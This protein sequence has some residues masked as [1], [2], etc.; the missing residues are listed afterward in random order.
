MKP[1]E[2]F[3]FS[4][5]VNAW[6]PVQEEHDRLLDRISLATYNVWFA[7]YLWRERFAGLLDT[8]RDWDPDLIALQEVTPRHLQHLLSLRWVRDHYRLSDV[9]GMTLQ[10]HGVLLLSKLPVR[11]L[12]MR[13]LPSN[14]HRKLLVAD[15]GLGPRSVRLGNLHLESSPSA[16]PIRMAQLDAVLPVLEAPTDRLLV[17]D[18]N[19]DPTQ[20]EEQATV[21]AH[22]QDLWTGL[23]PDDP[24]YTVDA[25]LNRMRR[26]HKRQ[27]KRVR[28]DRILWRSARPGW[29][30]ASVSV[31]GTVPIAPQRPDVFPSDHFGLAGSLVWVHDSF[32][33]ARPNPGAVPAR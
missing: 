25:T 28:Y 12:A 5:S 3:R 16:T 7:E 19:F 32:T 11:N 8:L 10:P 9:S 14:K 6:R 13:E 2:A 20:R 21:D 27:Q 17:G 4:P 33:S 30:P 15:L 23:R 26:L 24:G 31:I 29:Q 22:Y 1:L 18:F